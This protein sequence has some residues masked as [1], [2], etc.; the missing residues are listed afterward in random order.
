MTHK[1][2]HLRGSRFMTS[3]KQ[4]RISSGEHCVSSTHFLGDVKV[5][6]PMQIIRHLSYG[7]RNVLMTLAIGGFIL[8][9]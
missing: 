1:W 9:S 2:A 8:M 4:T 5:T 7:N 3:C 6:L